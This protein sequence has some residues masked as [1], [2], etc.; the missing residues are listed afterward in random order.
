MKGKSRLQIIEKNKFWKKRENTPDER[1]KAVDK[2]GKNCRY[3]KNIYIKR[4]KYSRCIK[5]KYSKEKK[6]IEIKRYLVQIK[7]N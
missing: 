1:K 6:N 5:R 7:V 3:K 4:V 2:K